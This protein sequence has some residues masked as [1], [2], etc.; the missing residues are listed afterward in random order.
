MLIVCEGKETEPNYFDQLKRAEPTRRNFS[1]TVKRGKGGSRQQIAQFAV[2]RKENTDT[3][4]DEI[5]CVID[6]EG[7]DSVEPMR[8]ALEL[9]RA[10]EIMPALSNP[11]FEVWVLAHFEK[12]GRVFLNSGQVEEKVNSHW[13]K[14]FSAP[15][16]K[17]DKSI[18]RRLSSLTD[19]AIANAKWVHEHHHDLG[20]CILDC[21]SA[22]EVYRLVEML[23]RSSDK[24]PPSI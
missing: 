16:D 11:A 12:T 6:T 7:P 21:N 23:R 8:Q 15:Y 18:Y 24:R 10:N 14:A 2:E 3:T 20:K 4:F 22:T 17:A 19:H 9:L 1:I 13:I 5:W